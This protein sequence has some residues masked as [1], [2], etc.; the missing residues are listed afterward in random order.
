MS[1]KNPFEDCEPKWIETL[2]NDPDC[3]NRAG[4]ALCLGE[5]G[6]DSAVRPL[7]EAL[8][9]DKSEKVRLEAVEAV[10]KICPQITNGKLRK[11]IYSQLLKVI[12]V[13]N[14]ERIRVEAKKV[15]IEQFPEGVNVPY[16]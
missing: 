4:E 7:C 2:K 1:K 12:F 8:L 3:E 5:L 15:I 11:H 13:E 10:H 9:N 16:K 6:S 14:S